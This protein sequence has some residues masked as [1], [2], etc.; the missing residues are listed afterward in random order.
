M[1][2]FKEHDQLLKEFEYS[3]ALD[4]VLKM[5]GFIEIDFS[6]K[7]KWKLLLKSDP[8]LGY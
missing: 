2:S 4:S 3:K 8:L 1:K 6:Y 5:V 7:E